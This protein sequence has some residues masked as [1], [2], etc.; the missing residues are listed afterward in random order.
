M[1][2]SYD[3]KPVA[4]AI[5]IGLAGA[6][7]SISRH[8]VG[9]GL[10]RFGGRLPY[11]TLAV[12][13]LGAFVIGVAMA[14]FAARGQLDTRVRSVITVGFL[15]GFTTYSAFAFETVTLLE[16]KQAGLAAAYVALTLVAAGGCCYLG[17]L[18]GRALR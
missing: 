14:W 8:V 9:L 4:L 13:V 11:A 18:L 10:A 6:A 2:S 5:Y 16:K 1:C 17:M 3:R 15:G 7:G 12:N